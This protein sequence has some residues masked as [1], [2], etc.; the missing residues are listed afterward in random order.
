M[1]SWNDLTKGT[2]VSCF[3]KEANQNDTVADPFKDLQEDIC[4]LGQCHS[5][6]VPEKLTADDVA[7]IHSN[8]ITTEAPMIDEEILALAT[9]KGEDKEDKEDGM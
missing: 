1:V 8:I 6:L 3:R 2:F 9:L 4:Q 5:D 7:H